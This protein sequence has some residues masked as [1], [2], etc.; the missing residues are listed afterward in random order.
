MLLGGTLTIKLL[1]VQGGGDR[2]G[3]TLTLCHC[4]FQKKR[5]MTEAGHGDSQQLKV[6]Q[7]NKTL[8]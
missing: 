5:S 4:E 1:E 8:L 2:G 7:G 6:D 3:C